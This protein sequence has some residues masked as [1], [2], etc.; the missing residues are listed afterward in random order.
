M[1]LDYALM[2]YQFEDMQKRSRVEGG[3]AFMSR[4]KSNKLAVVASWAVFI[5]VGIFVV[6]ETFLLILTFFGKVDDQAFVIQLN[7]LNFVLE[8]FL[9][10]NMLIFYCRN[11]GSPYIEPKFRKYVHKFG[12]VVSVWTIAF[13]LR[14]VFALSGI[15]IVSTSTDQSSAD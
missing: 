9:N 15:N 1:S 5:Y 8:I 13:A 14:L 4:F 10:T 12:V 6:L 7:V 11:S 2:Y 3:T